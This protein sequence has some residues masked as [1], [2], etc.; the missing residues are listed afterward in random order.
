MCITEQGFELT[1]ATLV[2]GSGQVVFDTLCVPASPITDYNTRYSGITPQMLQQ[3][4]T[5]LADVQSALRMLARRF[6][7]RDIQSGAHDSA[8]DARTALDLVRL[9][10]KHG[11]SFGLQ[12]DRAGAGA[13]RAKLVDVLCQ[14]HKLRCCLVDRP[15]VL[16]RHATGS[17]AAVPV[18]SDEAAVAKAGKAMV[19]GTYDFVWTQLTRLGQWLGNSLEATLRHVDRAVGELWSALPSNSLLLVATG[20]GDTG[21][22]ERL[23]EQ[24]AKRMAVEGCA[25]WR[26]AQQAAFEALEAVAMQ[27]LLFAAVKP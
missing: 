10:V 13:P 4:N 25:A 9:K 19:S 27:G 26:N 24:R 22:V 15:E 16:A 14:Q 8:I 7:D 5:R 1:R 11:P 23:R 20:Q 17:A 18:H 2:G 3:V 12:Q 6:L 21:E